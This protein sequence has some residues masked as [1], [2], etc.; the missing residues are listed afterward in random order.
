MY[1]TVN[2]QKKTQTVQ[3]RLENSSRIARQAIQWE[4]IG[5]KRKSGHPR[6]TWLDVVKRDFNDMDI[7]REEAE[8]L[9]ANRAGW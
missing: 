1:N 2:T 5:Y 3:S 7:T 8:E 6:K 9:A 4:L